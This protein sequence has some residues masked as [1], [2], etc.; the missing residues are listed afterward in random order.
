MT[1]QRLFVLFLLG[2]VFFNY[3]FLSLFDHPTQELGVPLLYAYLFA[4][5]G[6]FIVG[7]ALAVERRERRQRP[8]GQ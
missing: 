4:A 2:L 5:W 1:T 7:T 8:P 6:L 3:P